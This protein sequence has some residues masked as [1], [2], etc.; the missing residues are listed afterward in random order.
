[1]IISCSYTQSLCSTFLCSLWK[2]V[3][4]IWCLFMFIKPIYMYIVV[5]RTLLVLFKYRPQGPLSTMFVQCMYLQSSWP[6]EGYFGS[7]ESNCVSEYA[8]SGGKG[9]VAEAQHTYVY[10]C[11]NNSYSISIPC[12]CR[13]SM[14]LFMDTSGYI[15]WWWS[16]L[17]LHSSRDYATSSN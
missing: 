1:M 6:S 4:S 15:H 7:S 12:A 10:S 8:G 14:I 9:A 11:S 3:H 2:K 13:C 5:L 16:S 17:T